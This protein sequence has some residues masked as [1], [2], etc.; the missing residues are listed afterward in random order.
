M[1]KKSATKRRNKAVFP[2]YC[3]NLEHGRTQFERISD[4]L[5]QLLLD[6]FGATYEVQQ[7]NPTDSLKLVGHLFDIDEVDE[8]D[9]A[10]TQY[11]Q[12]Y[13]GSKE[14]ASLCLN[15]DMRKR[16]QFSVLAESYSKLE[17][18]IFSIFLI[19]GALAGTVFC[20]V[21]IGLGLLV[22]AI[23]FAVGALIGGGLY[24]L[25]A[26]PVVQMLVG[27]KAAHN[28]RLAKRLAT[29]VSRTLNSSEELTQVIKQKSVED[30][31]SATSPAPQPETRVD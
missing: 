3:E 13:R 17:D 20:A 31:A 24:S 26:D 1:A 16:K 9:A 2:I 14:G 18:A 7:A 8:Q 10:I 22:L 11:Y 15:W 28:K 27:D 6:E 25:F 19:I 29:L 30:Q 4:V 12:L 5:Y 23:A 21:S